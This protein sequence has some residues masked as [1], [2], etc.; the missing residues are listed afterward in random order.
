MKITNAKS[1]QRKSKTHVVTPTGSDTFTVTS[2]NSGNTY[3]VHVS[4]H[5][6]T[7]NCTWASYRPRG[8]QRSGCSHVIS[9]FNHIE[10]ENGRKVSAWASRE[11][12][13]RQHRPL[14]NI[15]DGVVLTSRMAQ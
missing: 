4:G 14:A 6:A 10:A 1:I 8:D 12:A 11:D 3:N 13:Q 15:G 7:C 9:V 2:G 5:G